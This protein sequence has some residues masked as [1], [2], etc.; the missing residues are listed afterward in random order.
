MNAIKR[1]IKLDSS[2][3]IESNS[4]L[5]AQTVSH[6]CAMESNTYAEVGHRKIEIRIHMS[7]AKAVVI[8]VFD[9]HELNGMN[10]SNWMNSLYAVIGFIHD[11]Q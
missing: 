3:E 8:S 4:I 10:S 5:V 7:D 9:V 2:L 11:K 6:S 1:V